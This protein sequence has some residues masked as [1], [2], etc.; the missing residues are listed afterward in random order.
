VA[1]ADVVWSGTPEALRDALNAVAPCDIVALRVL[2]VDDAFH[3]RFDAK[4][5]EYRYQ[6]VVADTPPILERRY[7]WWRRNALDV[8]SA[9]EACT[10]L[11]GRRAFGTFAGL[12]KSRA[13]S[14]EALTR[15]VSEC[16]WWARIEE[17]ADGH[18]EAQHTFRIVANGF[19][20]QMVRGMVAAVY[21]VARGARPVDWIEEIIAANDRRVLGEAAPPHGL[22]LWRV[23]Y[24]G[25]IEYGRLE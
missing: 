6:L 19:L 17:R 20:P 25:V 4:W 18:I 5:R 16:E 7:V 11:V 22:V 24:D 1:A 14:T 9:G 15:T 2:E 21:E 3:A 8:R 10:Q 12:G 13:A 23:S